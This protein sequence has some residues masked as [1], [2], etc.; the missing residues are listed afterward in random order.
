M[1]VVVKLDG[2]TLLLLSLLLLLDF[3]N[4]ILFTTLVRVI[5]KLESFTIV[6]YPTVVGSQHEE[7]VFFE[8]QVVSTQNEQL[9]SLPANEHDRLAQKVS[10]PNFSILVRSEKCF[11]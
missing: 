11:E 8:K 5:K 9:A 6:A 2:C 7:I 10:E 3:W 1:N 4:W